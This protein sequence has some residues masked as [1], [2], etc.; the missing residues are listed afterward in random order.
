MA[1]AAR[2][3]NRASL[4]DQAALELAGTVIMVD[5]FFSLIRIRP[6]RR[7]FVTVSRAS[8]FAVVLHIG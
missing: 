6:T 1:T 7:F 2:N 8:L 4:R 3:G 5:A